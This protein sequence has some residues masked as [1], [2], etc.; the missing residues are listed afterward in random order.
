MRCM[1]P[2][3]PGIG[4]PKRLC[5]MCLTHAIAPHSPQSTRFCLQGMGGRTEPPHA[6]HR[7]DYAGRA[8]L[9]NCRASAGASTASAQHSAATRS[10]PRGQNNCTHQGL[11]IGQGWRFRA[12]H[13]CMRRSRVLPLLAAGGKR[14]RSVL[15][16]AHL[17]RWVLLLLRIEGPAG[18]CC[19]RAARQN[20]GSPLRAASH[21]AGRASG[22]H[23]GSAVH[24]IRSPSGVARPSAAGSPKWPRGA[25]RSRRRK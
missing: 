12:W 14:R 2:P 6:A 20:V 19:P 16:D 10:C 22:S 13:A 23:G 8:A 21:S 18:R 24:R 5:A 17:V 4:T 15:P 3:S 9:C 25:A 7:A 1:A 11:N